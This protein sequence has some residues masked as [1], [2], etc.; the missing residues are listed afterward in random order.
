MMD[1]TESERLVLGR[2][3]DDSELIALLRA[4]DADRCIDYQRELI[5]ETQ[6]QSPNPNVMIQL[7]SKMA[8]RK[9]GVDRYLIKAGLTPRR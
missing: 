5:E 6:A 3:T 7:G 1:L 2:L 9:E 8:E 4:I